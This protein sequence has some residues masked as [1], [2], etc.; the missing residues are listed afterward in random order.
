V[1]VLLTKTNI[2]C[3]KGDQIE[4]VYIIKRC[5]NQLERQYVLTKSTT[6]DA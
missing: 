2:K 3:S 4:S 1:A 6:M 5:G